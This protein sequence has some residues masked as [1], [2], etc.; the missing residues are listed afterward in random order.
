MKT[1][2]APIEKIYHLIED[3]QIFSTL[4]FA[5]A[6]RAGFVAITLLRSLVKLGGLTHERLLEFQAS[7]P[8]VTSEFQFALS[9]SDVSLKD[10]INKFGHLR[11]GTYD[12]CQ[13]AYWE[14]PKFYFKF[15]II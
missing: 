5:H 14:D 2:L 8:T 13:K 3:C 15:S 9:N 7:I 6:A 1:E 4:A 11:P 10:L 12:V